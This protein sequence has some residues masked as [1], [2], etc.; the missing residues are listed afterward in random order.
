MIFKISIEVDLPVGEEMKCQT[1]GIGL[2][3]LFKR[4]GI[5][6]LK[7]KRLQ[8]IEESLKLVNPSIKVTKKVPRKPRKASDVETT[9]SKPKRTTKPK[10]ES[11][12][13]VATR[14]RT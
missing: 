1:I 4:H 2:D 14:R 6:I 5:P 7:A 10:T 11:S 13:S 12:G 3:K 9:V 8:V